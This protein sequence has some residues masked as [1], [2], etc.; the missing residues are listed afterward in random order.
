VPDRKVAVAADDVRVR[1]AEGEAPVARS[2]AET[3]CGAAWWKC[4]RRVAA[5]IEASGHGLDIRYVVTDIGRGS[6]E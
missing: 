1:W 6:A 3:R 4:G 5:R 2:H